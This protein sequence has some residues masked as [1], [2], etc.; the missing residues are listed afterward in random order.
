VGREIEESQVTPEERARL[1][2]AV[3]RVIA[4]ARNDADMTHQDL[5]N[6]LGLKR[7]QVVN[8]ERGRRAIHASELPLIAKVLG[9][10]LDELWQRILGFKEPRRSNRG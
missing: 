6:R 8:M 10:D 5:A 9:L 4:N 1:K 7:H 3:I 2:R